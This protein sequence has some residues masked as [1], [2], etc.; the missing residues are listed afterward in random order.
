MK[1]KQTGAVL[2]LMAFIVGLAATAYFVKSFN[3]ISSQTYQDKTTYLTLS[4]AKKALIAYAAS[5]RDFPGQLPFPDRNSDLNYDGFS[6]CNSPTSNFS[7]ALLIGQLPVFGQTNPCIAPQAGVGADF[8]DMQGNRFWYAVSRNLVHK[9]ESPAADPIINPSII[10]NPIYPWLKVFD[11][12]G[13]LISNRVAAVIIAPQNIVGS[14]NRAS[15]TAGA[16][17]FLDTATIGA[18][19]FSNADYDTA[20]EDFIAA[21]DSRNLNSADTT[22]TRPYDFNDKLVYITID[23]LI[24]ATTRRAAS[25]MQYL[26]NK[27]Q[28]NNAR[29]PYAA[30]LGS[31]FNNHDSIGISNAGMVPIDITD[32]CSCVSAQSCSCSFG[33]VSSVTFT[34]GSSTAFTASIGNCGFSGATCTCT[35]TGSC[36]SGARAFTCTGAGVCTHNINGASNRYDF[37]AQDYADVPSASAGCTVVAGKARCNGAGTFNIGLKESTWFKTNLWQ[38]YFYYQWS[39]SPSLQ[40]G[41]QT[42]ISALLIGTGQPLISETGIAQIRPSNNILDYLDSAENTNGNNTFD[43]QT[44]R[45]TDKYNDLPLIIEP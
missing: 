19:T 23:E 21:M 13:R 5:N 26:L 7:Y 17:E 22:Y 29:Y 24:A 18:S 6:D 11:A 43:K 39:A 2:I 32:T 35:G 33:R 31:S 41:T 30:N 12:Q 14:Q 38:D 10:N 15:S 4:A 36:L 45:H 20:D 42:G 28:T 9:Y 8:T 27:Y 40:V 34:R 3:A 16:T 44:K 1:V 37:T 25:D